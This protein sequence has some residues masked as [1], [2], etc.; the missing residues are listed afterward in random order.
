MREDLEDKGRFLCL[1]YQDD[2]IEWLDEI[3]LTIADGTDNELLRSAIVQYKDAVNGF[4][5]QRKEDIME[6]A[7]II[8]YLTSTYNLNSKASEK[9][10]ELQA[11]ANGF[12]AAMDQ[13]TIM[14]F[15]IELLELIKQAGKDRVSFTLD[16]VRESDAEKWMESCKKAAGNIGVELALEGV[17]QTIC[18]GLGIEF[19]GTTRDTAVHF[20]IMTHGKNIHPDDFSIKMP[21][22]KIHAVGNGSNSPN[23][24]W[25]ESTTVGP[26]FNRALFRYGHEAD[27][28][29]K[30]STLASNVFKYWFSIDTE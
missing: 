7:R 23:N 29:D 17:D 1:S 27:W 15:L 6:R 12:Q 3:L 5:G 19:S 16:Q 30:N 8:D 26:W 11:A 13:I 18:Y 2:I 21:V 10:K 9:I 25:W 22:K 4:C 20:G 24:W 14:Q 28:Q